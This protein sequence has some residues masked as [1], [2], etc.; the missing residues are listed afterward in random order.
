MGIG[1]LLICLAL[2]VGYWNSWFTGPSNRSSRPAP[3]PTQTS[4]Q[5]PIEQGST[6]SK[7][8]NPSEDGWKTEAISEQVAKT[9]SQ[10]GNVMLAGSDPEPLRSIV[11]SRYVSGSLLPKD[12]Q[13]VFNQESLEIERQTESGS[14]SHVDR[15]AETFKGAEGFALAAKSLTAPFRD[16]KDVRWKFKVF[17]IVEEATSVVT[18]QYVSLSGRTPDAV[19]EQNATWE[20]RWFIDGAS[21]PKLASI[22][23]VDFERVSYKNAGKTMFS[24]CTESVLGAN[25]SYRT[26]FLRGMNQ[27]LETSQ[28]TRYFYLLGNPG[29]AIGD[30]NGDGLD[31]M[32]VC[33]EEGIPNRLFLQ[34]ADGRAVDISQTWEVDWLHNSR[35]ALLVDLDND[36]DQDLV[37]AMIGHLIVASNESSRFQIRNILST[38]EDNMSLS[39]AD[40]DND[41]D[42]DIYVC[43]LNDNVAL[44]GDAQGRGA[45]AGLAGTG[46]EELEGGRNVLF[47]N[48]IGDHQT[49]TFTDV[50]Q[51]CGLDD[52][53]QRL[54]YA[55][56]WDDYDNDGDLDLYVANDYGQNNLFRND[57]GQFTDVTSRTGATDTAFGMSA[58]WGDY[59]RD[60][61]MDI[62][63]S[64]MFSAAGGRVTSQERFLQQHPQTKQRLQRFAKGN[65]LLRNEGAETGFSDVS[66][67]AAVAVGRWAWGS[68]FVDLNNDGWEDLVVAN[69]FLTTEDTGDL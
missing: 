12:R 58:S 49:W 45:I 53:N 50:T 60:G 10:L 57:D 59:D 61:W 38:D 19:I 16:A 37:V 4:G 55:A 29:M 1:S 66:E 62:Y 26:Q 40:Y 69:G 47:R 43:A 52:L 13:I 51:A 30:I 20:I 42:L 41:G 7:I 35:G 36:G 17:R 5:L 33:Q 25:E 14:T 63:V 31:D 18:R 24:D 23:V 9:L 56:S 64:N 3:A 65:T 67:S 39:S 44:R 27:W 34:T 6:W 2:V 48:E 21:Q 22:E 46:N 11:D 28:D 8:D 32:Y 68:N 15:V 54:S